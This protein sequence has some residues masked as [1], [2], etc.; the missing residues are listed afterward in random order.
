[1]ERWTRSVSGRPGT[2]SYRVKLLVARPSRDLRDRR[3]ASYW[4]DIDCFADSDNDDNVVHFVCEIPK[5]TT[6]K[7]EVSLSIPGNPIVQDLTSDGG[8]LR[9]YG[10]PMEWNYGMVPQTW[11]DDTRPWPLG[12]YGA[13]KGD[14]D[15]LDVVEVG[16]AT[17]VTGGVYTV[18]VLGVIGLI[19]QGQ[20]DWKIVALRT[21]D[22]MATHVKSLA[23]LRRMLPANELKRIVHWFRTYKTHE[24][25][26]LNR[27]VKRGRVMGTSYAME[28]VRHAHRAWSD[29]GL[30]KRV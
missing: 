26:G 14:G 27:F 1:M 30:Y 29:A 5:N 25:K 11:E 21:D 12:G 18:K 13:L 10:I 28:V 2:R 6:A 8:K 16:S 17:C 9:H 23:D 3:P 22:P 20:L 4:H 15:P 24:G 7:M 19:D